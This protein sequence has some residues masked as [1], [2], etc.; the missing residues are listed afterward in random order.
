VEAHGGYLSRLEQLESSELI[1]LACQALAEDGQGVHSCSLAVS[2]VPR[3]SVIRL[4]FDSP[5]TYGRRGARWYEEHHALARLL[6]RELHTTIH[7]YVLDPEEF[8][9]VVTYAGGGKVGGERLEYDQVDDPIDGS[10]EEFAE[11][12]ARWPLGYLA[13][14]LGVTREDLVKL[15]RAPSALLQLDRASPQG[16]LADLLPPNAW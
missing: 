12:N 3:R 5:H 2:K 14:I 15:P 10:D 9:Q 8:E 16:T 7:A 11:L 4:A 6:S 13:R 1:R